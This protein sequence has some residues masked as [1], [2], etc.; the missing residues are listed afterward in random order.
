M[1]TAISKI[2]MLALTTLTLSQIAWAQAMPQ[3]NNNHNRPRELC[4]GDKVITRD[5]YSGKVVALYLHQ[6]LVEIKVDGSRGFTDSYRTQDIGLTFG[7]LE[8]GNACVGQVV[9]HDGYSGII[10]AILPYTNEAFV[11]YLDGSWPELVP[12]NDLAFGDA[13][14]RLGRCPR[15]NGRLRFNQNNN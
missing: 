4:T 7:C 3:F 1:N 2:K 8:R 5:G 6:N 14:R 10:A 9:Y 11:D 15:Q 12:A 13:C